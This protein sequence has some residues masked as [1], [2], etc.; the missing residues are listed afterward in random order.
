M[1]TA[2]ENWAAT[3][4]AF[5]AETAVGAALRS[6]REAARNTGISFDEMTESGQ[7]FR[8]ALSG[9]SSA[10][11]DLIDTTPIT[12]Q[13]LVL[14]EQ[15]RRL[16]ETMGVSID[17][18]WDWANSVGVSAESVNASVNGA[19]A[20]LE[21]LGGKFASLPPVVLTEIAT[22]G[23]PQTEAQVDALVAKYD[24]TEGTRTTLMAV[25]SE[26]A[27]LQIT[28]YRQMLASIPP[29]V[30]TRLIIE[31]LRSRASSTP[32]GN[33]LN[34]YTPPAGRAGGQGAIRRAEGGY[35]S[36]PGGPREDAIP[37]WLSNGEYVIN[38]E[39]TLMY[40]PVLEA[41]NQNRFADG[42]LVGMQPF[43]PAAQRFARGSMAN[44]A[45]T[46]QR[47]LPSPAVSEAASVAV[48]VDQMRTMQSAF[49]RQAQAVVRAVESLPAGVYDGA[50]AGV[51]DEKGK[52]S[53]QRKVG[54]R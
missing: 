25:M 6:V 24:L 13:G 22:Y 12:Q 27:E 34:N 31:E 35:V 18:A 3:L 23:I 43:Q 30:R 33:W 10:T 21:L 20:Q 41:I 9:W 17:T 37:A 19:T 32:T 4:T 1:A 7:A 11:R 42:G 53:Q 5:D 38:A 49:T 50:R 15:I 46:G 51:R 8:G 16:S 48:A 26:S 14:E 36:G 29:S 44:W 2:Y 39:A 54:G 52:F 28:N 45:D 47:W 40:R